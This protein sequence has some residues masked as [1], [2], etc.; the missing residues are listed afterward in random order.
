LD[1]GGFA[2]LTAELDGIGA[3]RAF[4]LEGGYDLDAL[5]DSLDA[6]IQAVTP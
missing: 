2:T 4:V 1:A 5:R 3:G 6:V